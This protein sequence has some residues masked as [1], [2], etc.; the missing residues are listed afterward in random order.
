MLL[1]LLAVIYGVFLIVFGFMTIP[2]SCAY[3]VYVLRRQEMELSSFPIILQSIVDDLNTVLGLEHELESRVIERDTKYTRPT[4]KSSLGR[5]FSSFRF[6]FGGTDKN[7]QKRRVPRKRYKITVDA[8]VH[9]KAIRKGATGSVLP[10]G[11]R[12]KTFLDSEETPFSTVKCPKTPVQVPFDLTNCVISPHWS[13]GNYG[14][15]EK[16]SDLGDVV[17]PRDDMPPPIWPSPVSDVFQYS[18]ERYGNMS[19]VRVKNCSQDVGGMEESGMGTAV[20]SPMKGWSSQMSRLSL[21]SKVCG[22]RSGSVP[23][24][25]D[26]AS[27][28][29][30]ELF[31]RNFEN[32][33]LVPCPEIEENVSWREPILEC[34]FVTGSTGQQ[35]SKRKNWARKYKYAM[36]ELEGCLEKID[37]GQDQIT[38]G[39]SEGLKK[40]GLDESG[41]FQAG[42]YYGKVEEYENSE[43]V[44]LPTDAKE[45]Y[46]WAQ[47]QLDTNQDLIRPSKPSFLGRE[48]GNFPSEHFEQANLSSPKNICNDWRSFDRVSGPC[49]INVPKPW[50]CDDRSSYP[51]AGRWA[52]KGVQVMRPVNEEGLEDTRDEDCTGDGGCWIDEPSPN[53]APAMPFTPPSL[54]LYLENKAANEKKEN[55]PNFKHTHEMPDPCP[56]VVKTGI[57]SPNAND[58]NPLEESSNRA[59]RQNWIPT[60]PRSMGSVSPP[61]LSPPGPI[62]GRLIKMFEDMSKPRLPNSGHTSASSSPDKFETDGGVRLGKQVIYRSPK[63]SPFLAG[64]SPKN[65]PYIPG[66]ETVVKD[67][68]G[69][70]GDECL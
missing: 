60:S 40:L 53:P 12:F 58:K 47:S 67:S 59:S 62:S 61:T 1:P 37:H 21:E 31:I 35:S 13:T 28:I 55:G 49:G 5:N 9:K 68:Y 56:A 69:E 2:F 50:T 25:A 11:H 57:Y 10:P 65:S 17:S 30:E 33:T 8:T 24:C 27:P 18:G 38:Q 43:S 19:P 45:Q 6:N 63:N 23:P 41:N 46:S 14:D 54:Q 26:M 29:E 44:N 52:F 42:E 4:R 20:R 48:Q 34:A 64:M 7:S 36:V 51:F 70:L 32:K 22:G 16:S 3:F 15:G 66:I 39:K